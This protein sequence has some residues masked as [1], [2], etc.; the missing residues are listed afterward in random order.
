M[1][2]HLFKA[3]EESPEETACDNFCL[4]VDFK[5]ASADLLISSSV[6]EGIWRKASELLTSES[7]IAAAPGLASQARTVISKSRPGFHTVVPGKGGRHVCDNCPNYKSLGICSHTVAVA[8]ANGMLSEFIAWFR[9]SKNVSPNLTKLLT[10]DM[11]QGRGRKGGKGPRKRKDTPGEILNRISLL[12]RC[13]TDTRTSQNYLSSTPPPSVNVTAPSSSS[14]FS[15]PS[16]YGILGYD[17]QASSSYLGSSDV[18]STSLPAHCGQNPLPL[19]PLTPSIVGI[20]SGH[21]YGNTYNTLVFPD[22]AEAQYQSAQYTAPSQQSR[23]PPPLIR[24]TSSS[25]Q[26]QSDH[27]QFELVFLT[28]RVKKCYGCSNE[29]A[30]QPDG[31]NL[32]PPYDIVIHHAD[33][34]EYYYDGEKR[35]TKQKQN[36]YFHPS[37]T[38]IVSKCSSFDP[39]LS[40]C[41]VS[42]MT[43]CLCISLF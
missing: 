24:V 19:R 31:S 10:S 40:I 42:R 14:T 11:P 3:A 34:R 30:K 38:C 21:S 2:R 16:K 20:G 22:A 1:L 28:K 8:E 23:L 4:S 41:P 39:I 29:F 13:S 15:F 27:D 6:F 5:C 9:K 17:S 36:T 18:P 7:A 32:P 12:P 43:Y 37:L 26:S 33:Y 25:P 35:S